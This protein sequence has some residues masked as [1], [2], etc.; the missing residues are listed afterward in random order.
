M[1]QQSSQIVDPLA[2]VLKGYFNEIQQYCYRREKNASLGLKFTFTPMHGVGGDAV[3]RAFEA[4]NLPEFVPVPEQVSHMQL[5]IKDNACLS[6]GRG[7]M[8]AQLHLHI[9][10]EGNIKL[11]WVGKID[12]VGKPSIFTVF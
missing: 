3:K 1:K 11:K 7:E 4:F 8:Y 12:L 6:L 5:E 2:T 9:F 10:T